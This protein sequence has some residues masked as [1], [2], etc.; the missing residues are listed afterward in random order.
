M[1]LDYVLFWPDDGRVA[2]EIS[3]LDDKYRV[4]YNYWYYKLC[5]RW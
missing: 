3:C 1:Y 4:L 5:F 2:A